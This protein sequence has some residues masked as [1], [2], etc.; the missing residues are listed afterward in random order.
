MQE[1]Y[2]KESRRTNESCS[3]IDDNAQGPESPHRYHAQDWQAA[4]TSQSQAESP[5]QQRIRDKQALIPQ[6]MK[7]FKTWNTQ[8]LVWCRVLSDLSGSQHGS[9]SQGRDRHAASDMHSLIDYNLQSKHNLFARIL[10]PNL[11]MYHK[12]HLVYVPWT[13][14]TASTSAAARTSVEISMISQHSHA[15]CVNY[16]VYWQW[17]FHN[18]IN[19]SIY[20]SLIIININSTYS[21][22]K[23]SH[24]LLAPWRVTTTLSTSAKLI[25]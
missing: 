4:Q 21:T 19:N 23:R 18:Y 24:Q 3:L 22:W 10:Y 15:D 2:L 11:R 20:F 16:S 14:L 9:W 6:V 17:E 8:Q 12:R 5:V 25:I 13:T 7:Q 1:V